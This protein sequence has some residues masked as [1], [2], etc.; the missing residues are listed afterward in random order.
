MITSNVKN[1]LILKWGALGD[2]IMATSTIKAIR[3]NYP[4]AKITMFTNH[5]MNDILPQGFIVD[6]YIFLKKNGPNVDDSFFIHLY[7]IWKLRKRKFD[8]AVDLKWKS[9]RASVL[10]YLSGAKIKVGYWERIYNKCYTHSVKH[11]IGGYHEVHRNLDVI[12]Q[13]GLKVTD[14]NPLVFI[15]EEDKKSADKYFESNSIDKNNT[16]CIH[17]GA[18]KPNRAWSSERFTQL[19]DR[20]IKKYN[21]NIILTWGPNEFDLVKNISEK[22]GTNVFLSPPTKSVSLLAAIIQNCSMF[23][24]VCTGPMNVANAVKTPIVA[25]LGSTDPADWSPYGKIHRTIKSPL[26]LET[27]TD[28]DERKAFDA[29][30]VESVWDVVDKRWNELKNNYL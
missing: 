8:L 27:Y 20:L 13:I 12:K 6:E 25:L 26:V 10:T 4:E 16:I 17:V 23:I 14:E 11:P 1:I 30:T 5:L 2:L 9:E 29:I 3:E 24:S 28:E 21:V 15:S 19:A 7:K 22:L 18:S